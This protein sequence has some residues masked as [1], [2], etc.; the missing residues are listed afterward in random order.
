MKYL[1]W[2]DSE[3]HTFWQLR[4]EQMGLLDPKTEKKIRKN[5]DDVSMTYTT[6]GTKHRERERE[7][8]RERGRQI[9]VRICYDR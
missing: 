8:E 1:C 2:V 4:Y 7:R 3:P 6:K 5:N 9:H